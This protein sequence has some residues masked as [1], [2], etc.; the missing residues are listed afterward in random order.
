LLLYWDEPED[1]RMQT[2]EEARRDGL[3]EFVFSTQA[4]EHLL[5]VGGEHVFAVG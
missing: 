5:A 2:R 1:L 4:Q 3:K